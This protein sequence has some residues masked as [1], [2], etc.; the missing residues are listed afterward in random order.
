MHGKANS[1]WCEMIV[2]QCSLFGRMNGWLLMLLLLLLLCVL[3]S[4][5]TAG[6]IKCYFMR[7]MIFLSARKAFSLYLNHVPVHKHKTQLDV[8]FAVLRFYPNNVVGGL[9]G[10]RDEVMPCNSFEIDSI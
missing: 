9:G 4:I 3:R 7:R 5:A 1:L 6:S 10:V 2:A 8:I